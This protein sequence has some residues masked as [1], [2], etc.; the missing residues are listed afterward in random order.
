LAIGFALFSPKL[1][2]AA[3]GREILLLRIPAE[4]PEVHRSFEH[5]DI[6]SANVNC[7]RLWTAVECVDAFEK[8]KGAPLVDEPCALEIQDVCALS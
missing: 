6:R 7:T 3:R 2:A 1:P 4:I 8:Q 5:C